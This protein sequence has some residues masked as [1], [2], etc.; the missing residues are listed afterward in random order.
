MLSSSCLFLATVIRIDDDKILSFNV[1]LLNAVW[2]SNR[3]N[4]DFIV[5]RVNGRRPADA[6]TIDIRGSLQ[7]KYHLNLGVADF[8]LRA[9]PLVDDTA[10][11]LFRFLLN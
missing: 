7:K 2:E 6:P 11:S 3:Y 5:L 8:S 4:Y 1:C 9:Y 10:Q